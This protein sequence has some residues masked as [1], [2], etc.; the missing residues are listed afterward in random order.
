MHISLPTHPSLQVLRLIH[1]RWPQALTRLSEAISKCWNAYNQV[2]AIWHVRGALRHGAICHGA[3]CHGA[4]ISEPYVDPNT[5]HV[6]SSTRSIH[7]KR[8]TVTRI[9]GPDAN[10][11][12]G[13]GTLISDRIQVTAFLL[14]SAHARL[15]TH[16][17]EIPCRLLVCTILTIGGE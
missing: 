10:T 11:D 13:G 17:D 4:S 3:I 15:H 2:A 8:L 6:T 7:G 5:F 14:S 16:L 9:E 12:L 1:I